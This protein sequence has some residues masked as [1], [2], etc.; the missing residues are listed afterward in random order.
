MLGGLSENIYIF[1]FDGTWH[2]LNAQ[3]MVANIIQAVILWYAICKD[4]CG[5]L[6]PIKPTVLL[7]VI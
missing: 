1:Q 6:L 5:K 7:E 2:I 3:Q 4:L